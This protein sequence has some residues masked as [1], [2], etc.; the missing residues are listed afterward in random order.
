MNTR[1]TSS[2]FDVNHATRLCVV[3]ALCFFFCFKTYAA[4][5]EN[6]LTSKLRKIDEIRVEV[7]DLEQARQLINQLY[8]QID[9]ESQPHL[10]QQISRQDALLL[11]DENS[12]AQAIEVLKKALV[13]ANESEN[14]YDI[15]KIEYDIATSEIQLGNYEEA[16]RT[17]NRA[18]SRLQGKEDNK[19][20]ELYADISSILSNA[21]IAFEL[22]EEA[23]AELEKAVDIY[24]AIDDEEGIATSLFYLADLNVVIANY[25]A[26]ERYLSQTYEYD[27]KSG[28]PRF[29]A[30]TAFQLGFVYQA[31]GNES[32][33]LE[34]ASNALQIYKDLKAPIDIALTKELLL[35]IEF[36]FTPLPEQLN[37]AYALLEEVQKIG[38]VDLVFSVYDLLSRMLLHEKAYDEA[39]S[40]LNTAIDKAAALGQGHDVS[41]LKENLHQVLAR[42]GDFA[43]AYEQLTTLRNSELEQYDRRQERLLSSIKLT[44]DLALQQAK[45][46]VLEQEKIQA[47][48][49]SLSERQTRTT[50][51][52]AVVSSFIVL[53]GLITVWR[54]KK[55][56]VYLQEKVNQATADLDIANKELNVALQNMEELSYTDD[57]TKLN[58]RRFVQKQYENFSRTR[59]VLDKQS[60]RYLF[61][62]DIDKFKSIND[63]YGHD[64]GDKVLVEFA[65]RLKSSFR[66]GD[67]CVRW[68]GEEFAVIANLP[69]KAAAEE[70]ARMVRANINSTEFNVIDDAQSLP[71]RTSFGVCRLEES[72]LDKT[73]SYWINIVDSLLYIAKES[74]RDTWIILDDEHII[75]DSADIRQTVISK[76]QAF[77]SNTERL[78]ENV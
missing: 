2:W 73:L 75:D 76:P 48:L 29:I 47:E 14:E 68:G 8:E 37:S 78:L 43:S 52:I 33:A 25:E 57:L 65:K 64:I 51:L 42:K 46:E 59:R 11:M 30:S 20:L 60:E 66:N 72:Y 26:A 49:R 23:I 53:I 19:S 62:F 44:S 61:L 27:L 12:Y 17:L 15:S 77:I 38:D 54:K 41:F 16:L 1:C 45:I 28:I 24:T 69:N 4:I 6:Q 55:L 39:N 5:D 35:D 58:N 10:Y 7:G 22:Y 56:A 32:K 70:K 13:Y 71:V 3:C 40:I 9:A 21:L 18:Q 63:T 34:M 31:L 67:L 36:T 74:G 50:Q